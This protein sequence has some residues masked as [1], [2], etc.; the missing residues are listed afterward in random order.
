MHANVNTRLFDSE[1]GGSMPS[2]HCGDYKCCICPRS[3]VLQISRACGIS[4][5]PH[6]EG[7]VLRRNPLY[8]SSLIMRWPSFHGIGPGFLDH[9]AALRAVLDVPSS[10]FSEGL[11]NLTQNQN[12]QGPILTLIQWLLKCGTWLKDHFLHLLGKA[13]G[14]VEGL[15]SVLRCAACVAYPTLLHHFAG[16][17]NMPRAFSS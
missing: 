3:T 17:G 14:R 11:S 4:S 6:R 9:D 10:Q 7:G 1:R 16:M 2:F 12:W 5:L 8:H 13:P 15:G